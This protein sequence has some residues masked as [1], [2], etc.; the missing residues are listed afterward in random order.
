ME[1]MYTHG[2]IHKQRWSKMLK[3]SMEYFGDIVSLITVNFCLQKKVSLANFKL[4][5]IFINVT[6]SRNIINTVTI[7]STLRNNNGGGWIVCI[8]GRRFHSTT[9][10]IPPG[11]NVNGKGTIM[12]EEST[13]GRTQ[14]LHGIAWRVERTRSPSD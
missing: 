10:R 11:D 8:A 3:Q 14:F 1:G 5:D 9:E 13:W 2:H 6:P 12:V 4:K 7:F